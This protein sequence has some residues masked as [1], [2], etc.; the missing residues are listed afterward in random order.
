MD[1]RIGIVLRLIDESRGTLQ[2]SSGQIGNL[3]GLGEASVLRLFSREVGKPLRRYML[4]VRMARAAALLAN[5]VTPIKTIAFDCRYTQVSNFYRD[6]K[7]VHGISPMQMRVTQ[8]KARLRG[9]QTLLKKLTN[10]DSSDNM[11]RGI[12]YS[13]ANFTASR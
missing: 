13:A 2:M 4:E 10:C 11:G 8:M 3:L 5:T 7:Q 12:T 9:K 1:P 6:F